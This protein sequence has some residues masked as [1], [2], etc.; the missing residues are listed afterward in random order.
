MAYYSLLIGMLLSPLWISCSIASYEETFDE[1]IIL[2]IKEGYYQESDYIKKNDSSIGPYTRSYLGEKISESG[3]L[4]F[5]SYDEDSPQLVSILGPDNT[6]EFVELKEGSISSLSNKHNILSSTSSP[7]VPESAPF[8]N[9]FMNQLKG[10]DI[11]AAPYRYCGNLFITFPHAKGNKSSLGRA[12]GSGILIGP[13]HVLTV[14]HNVF[15]HERGGWAQEVIFTPAQHKAS[16]P[17]GETKGVILKTF[18]NWITGAGTNYDYDMGLI[19]LDEPVGYK[20]GWAGLIGID[21]SFF[22]SFIQEEKKRT[23]SFTNSGIS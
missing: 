6:C 22:S 3:D 16:K 10:R 14:G 12:L 18:K 20:A 19:I 5:I 17:F 4:D 15:D 13:N 9:G 23:N 2:S 21:D 11:N 1:N 8:D 7:K